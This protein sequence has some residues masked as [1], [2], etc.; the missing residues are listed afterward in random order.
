VPLAEASEAYAVAILDGEET[1]RTLNGGAPAVVY[2]A[3]EQTADFGDLP[4]AISLSISQVSPT[5]G[6]GVAATGTV[7]V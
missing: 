6:P 4:E 5:E 2:A 1:L 3:S 7:H